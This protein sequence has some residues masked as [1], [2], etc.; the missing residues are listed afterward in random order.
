MS[1]R[2][3]GIW[4]ARQ[5]SKISFW[6]LWAILCS[7]WPYPASA[8][9]VSLLM[10]LL[11]CGQVFSTSLT[12]FWMHYAQYLCS[13]ESRL[14]ELPAAIVSKQIVQVRICFS[15]LSSFIISLLRWTDLRKLIVYCCEFLFFIE[16]ACDLIDPLFLYYW[17]EASS[18][19]SLLED[20]GSSAPGSASFL[21]SSVFG[22][23]FSSSAGAY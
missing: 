19:S 15:S 11:H 14:A 16:I 21:S 6:R 18:S 10:D 2:L 3:T 8:S 9:K 4:Q 22:S 13:Q 23:F 17:K 7:T 1:A 5:V 20:S 12:H